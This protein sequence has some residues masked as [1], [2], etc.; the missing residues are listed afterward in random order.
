[1]HRSWFHKLLFSYLPVFFI[2]ISLLIA[3]FFFSISQV[4]QEAASTVNR[5][6]AVHTLEVV[7][8]SLRTIEY[9]MIKEMGTTDG[10]QQFFNSTLRDDSYR[11]MVEPSEKLRDIV[12]QFPMIHSVYM[13]RF[14]DNVVL[15]E[16]TAMPLHEF[17]DRAFIQV[18]RETKGGFGWTGLRPYREFPFQN[19]ANVVTLVK[20]YPLPAGDQGIMVVNVSAKSLQDM[21]RDMFDSGFIHAVLLD[22]ND[23]FV[24]GSADREELFPEET[25]TEVQSDYTGWRMM[26]RFRGGAF[27]QYASHLNIALLGSGVLVIIA[28]VIYI[29]Y[30]SKRNYRPLQS[31]TERV[32]G[33]SRQKSEQLLKNGGK[34]EFLFIEQALDQMIEQSNELLSQQE[35]HLQIRRREWVKDTL[36]G[37]YETVGPMWQSLSE[38]FGWN[39]AANRASVIIVEIDRYMEFCGRYSKRDQS[40]LKFLI[41]NVVSEIAFQRGI[42]LFGEWLFPQKWCAII[43]L[44]DGLSIEDTALFAQQAVNWIQN[45]LEFSV[46]LGL[47][48][49]VYGAGEISA[50]YE[51]AL[52]ALGY[53]TALGY[54]RVIGH[55]EVPETRGWTM[56]R[57]AADLRALTL[58]FKLGEADWEEHYDLFVQEL[59]NNVCSKDELLN[60]M[61]DLAYQL[62]REL[63]DLSAEFQA[64]WTEETMPLLNL[65]LKHFDTFEELN[66]G[67]KDILR[68]A[69]GR[70]DRLR[71]ERS[72]SS[73]MK[74]VRQYI[75]E[76]YGNA[77][78]S[79]NHLSSAFDLNAKNVSHLFKEEFGEK[80]VEYLAN[81]R[82]EK[83]K[84]LLATTNLSIQDV[85]LQVGYMHSFSFIRVFKK[86]VGMTPG[87]YRKH[88]T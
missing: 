46:T 65:L 57:T 22:R 58:S 8:H 54:D 18:Y 2:V 16:D 42:E 66:V 39:T 45:N 4:T 3:V 68:V 14:E 71:E 86:V 25:L 82:M 87:D 48:D 17:E 56:R 19:T 24:Q 12:T 20:Q 78:L 69:F 79:L 32:H 5:G 36:E 73:T 70:M 27:Y 28:A 80:F 75:Y 52:H 72:N 11:R 62:S 9:M 37:H 7:D 38:R 59:L 81:V 1:M 31:L 13:V 77:D 35:E 10:I 60:Q 64:V 74:Q 29:T 53:K 30:I 84:T 44:E 88:A 55:W 15:S 51:Q 26:S 6:S 41:G 63:M 67:L 43:Q 21:V 47:G 85:A 76:N 49:I 83:A 23:N 34:D 61:N 50:S 40:L 33:Y